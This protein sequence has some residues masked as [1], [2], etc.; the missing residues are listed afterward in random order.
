MKIRLDVKNHCIETEVRRLH[1]AG[2]SRYFRG[3]QDRHRVEGELML[4]KKAL[5]AF[6]FARLRSHWPMLAGGDDGEVIL[7][8]SENRLPCLKFDDRDIVPPANE[9]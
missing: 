1:E 7:T 6:D 2:I 5:T 3:G 4:L 9:A 8:W